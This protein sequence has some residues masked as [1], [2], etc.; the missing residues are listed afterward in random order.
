MGTNPTEGA[1]FGKSADEVH[2]RGEP[3][4]VALELLQSAACG[5]A[6]FQD[7]HAS[8]CLSEQCAGEEAAE[9]AADDEDIW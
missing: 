8:P 6:S 9:A 7:G 5:V 1:P 4:A 3:L 2:P